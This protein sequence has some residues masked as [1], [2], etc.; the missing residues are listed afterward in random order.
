MK[1]SIMKIG[2]LSW[3]CRQ[4]GGEE[5]TS[6]KGLEIRRL[7]GFATGNPKALQQS[8]LPVWRKSYFQP[9]ILYLVKLLIADGKIFQTKRLSINS[10]FVH[11]TFGGH[12]FTKWKNQARKNKLVTLGNKDTTLARRWRTSWGSRPEASRLTSWY[13]WNSW[14]FGKYRVDSYAQESIPG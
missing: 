8:V 12:C 1:G 5:K 2:T 14:Y 11:K 7:W 6:H 9:G 4:W 3:I 10:C 13:W